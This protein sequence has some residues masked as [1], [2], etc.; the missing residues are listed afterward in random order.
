M[1]GRRPARARGR[2]PPGGRLGR[3]GRHSRP[4][5][6]VSMCHLP[7]TTLGLRRPV[8]E[9][10]VVGPRPLSPRE[11]EIDPY[12]LTEPA[13]GRKRGPRPT[14][15]PVCG[16]G[17]CDGRWRETG[18]SRSTA[19]R[20]SRPTSPTRARST[21]CRG[22]G[23][24][25]TRARP[26][27]GGG[28]AG[29]KASFQDFH[30][31][32]RISKASPQLFLS[33]ATGSTTRRASLSG[34]RAGPVKG[35]GR[36]PEVQAH[37]RP[38]DERAA[39]RR[40]RRRTRPPSSSRSA[41]AASRSASRPRRPTGPSTRR[42]PPASTSSQ[43]EGLTPSADGGEQEAL[44][45][46]PAD[47]RQR[48]A[49]QGARRPLPRTGPPRR[50]RRRAAASRRRRRRWP[51]PPRPPRPPGRAPRSGAAAGRS[52]TTPPRPGGP[53]RRGPRRA[54]PGGGWR[55]D[56]SPSWAA[57]KSASSNAAPRWSPHG[58]AKSC[59]AS[60]ARNQP[61]PP[62]PAGAS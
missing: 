41:T 34:R 3:L 32:A 18:S 49:G 48:G 12:R 40:R 36:L 59:A 54:R 23:G 51:R 21:C 30:F 16:V 60:S 9:V 11:R 47:H 20:V 4:D 33:C 42:R 55:P 8:V 17:H 1:G 50:G 2:V 6:N 37:R 46:Q 14:L 31:V 26:G 19:S 5:P 7:T 53:A 25:P 22:R 58:M 10:I 39:E 13:R 43:Q 61:S 45:D 56:R 57:R 28:G 35:A 24:S 44:L 15:A 29:G 27:P 62:P 52:P 38:G